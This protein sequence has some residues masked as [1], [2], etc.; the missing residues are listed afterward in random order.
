[1]NEN[2]KKAIDTRRPH[3]QLH[4]EFLELESGFSADVEGF[5][6]LMGNKIK[7]FEF[8]GSVIQALQ[9]VGDFIHAYADPR[10]GKLRLASFECLRIF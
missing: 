2:I 5:L 9:R 7:C 6:K 10:K 8:G 1:M 4:P 3:H